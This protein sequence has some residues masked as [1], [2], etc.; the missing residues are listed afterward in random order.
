MALGF[1]ETGGYQKCSF[2][3]VKY[4]REGNGAISSEFNFPSLEF[5]LGGQTENIDFR[6]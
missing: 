1:T 3:H 2:E 6:N 4:E 5:N